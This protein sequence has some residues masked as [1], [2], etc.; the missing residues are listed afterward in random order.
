MDFNICVTGHINGHPG[1][2]QTEWLADIDEEEAVSEARKD[3]LTEG[4]RIGL[5][6][7]ERDGT[8]RTVT[9]WKR[10]EGGELKGLRPEDIQDMLE[11]VKVS[12]QLQPGSRDL[13]SWGA[14]GGEI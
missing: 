10:I 8:L 7:L 5:F 1:H 4:C 11:V 3:G 13:G 2:V 12:V 14:H 6:A 9:G